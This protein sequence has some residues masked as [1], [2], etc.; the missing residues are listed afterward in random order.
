MLDIGLSK[1]PLYRKH[2]RNLVFVILF[3][4]SADTE[5]KL[6]LSLSERSLILL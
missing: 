3:V 2:L 6:H 5:L 4:N 1:Q